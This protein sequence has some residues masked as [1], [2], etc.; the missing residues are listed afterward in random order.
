ML[1]V[2]WV[3]MKSKVYNIVM[4]CYLP[5]NLFLNKDSKRCSIQ[6]NMQHVYSYADTMYGVHFDK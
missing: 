6:V 5:V 1:C 2:G 3:S 4:K